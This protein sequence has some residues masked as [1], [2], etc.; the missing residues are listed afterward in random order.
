MLSDTFCGRLA[1]RGQF[2][3]GIP[4]EVSINS[5]SRLSLCAEFP[6]RLPGRHLPPNPVVRSWSIGGAIGRRNV[7]P[8]K[9]VRWRTGLVG[10]AALLTGLAVAGSPGTARAAAAGPDAKTATPSACD[11]ANGIKHVVQLTFD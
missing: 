1:Q 11:L 4:R 2:T 6:Y 7:K 3:E 9:S 8:G 5:Q 10:S